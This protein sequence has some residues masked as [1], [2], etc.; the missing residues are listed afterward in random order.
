MK[1]EIILSKKTPAAISPYS[2]ALKV[3]NLLF[4]SG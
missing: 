2:P 4:A 3:G 1:K